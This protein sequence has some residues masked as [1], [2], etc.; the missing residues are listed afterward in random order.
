MPDNAKYGKFLRFQKTFPSE[1]VCENWLFH[2]FWPDGFVCPR[3]GHDRF[4]PIPMRRQY[5][6]AGCGSQTA[7]TGETFLHKSRIP[8][9]KWFWAIALYD[10]NSK[11]SSAEL[12]RKLELPKP[13]AWLI[14]KKIRKALTNKNGRLLLSAIANS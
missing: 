5:E 14:L 11:I 4:Y 2:Y 10:E 9:H 3:C 1:D 12:G 7:L 8:M 13:T 6:C